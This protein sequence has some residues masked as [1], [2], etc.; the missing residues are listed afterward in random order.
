MLTNRPFKSEVRHWAAVQRQLGL[1]AS[2]N[3][4]CRRRSADSSDIGQVVT[5]FTRVSLEG[6]K[7]S[8]KRKKAGWHSEELIK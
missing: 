2:D 3:Y 6:G 8:P 4:L 7:L 5:P 1:P